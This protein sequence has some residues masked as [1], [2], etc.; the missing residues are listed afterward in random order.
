M[1][2]CRF[3]HFLFQHWIQQ[4]VT[5]GNVQSDKVSCLCIQPHSDH[6][7]VKIFVTVTNS[8]F[9]SCP[10]MHM[11]SDPYIN[12]YISMHNYTYSNQTCICTLIDKCDCV[13][14][15][16]L[17]L[18]SVDIGSRKFLWYNGYIYSCRHL[19]YRII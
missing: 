19:I 8:I 14:V 15:D 4:N 16:T 9:V 12:T 11:Q 18:L 7:K 17:T 1:G 3:H 10:R 5:H 6:V 2:T 13:S